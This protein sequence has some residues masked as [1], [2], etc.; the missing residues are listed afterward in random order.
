MNGL[1][2]LLPLNASLPPMYKTSHVSIAFD[3]HKAVDEIAKEKIADS[4]LIAG[5][6]Y[7]LKGVESES[8]IKITVNKETFLVRV[9][10]NTDSVSFYKVSEE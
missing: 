9:N 7:F 8:E 2:I 6:A 3:R 10:K 1:P 4:L 5:L